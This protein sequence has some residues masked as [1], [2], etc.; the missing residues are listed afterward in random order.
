LTQTP[1]MPVATQGPVKISALFANFGASSVHG[2]EQVATLSSQ[3]SALT[4]KN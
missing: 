2:K 1:T 3:N 4:G